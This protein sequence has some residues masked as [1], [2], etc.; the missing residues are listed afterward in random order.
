MA[1]VALLYAHTKNIKVF[2]GG[3]IDFNPEQ[4]IIEFNTKHRKGIGVSADMFLTPYVAVKGTLAKPRL[5]LNQKGALLASGAAVATGGI[6]MLVRAA[7]DRAAGTVDACQKYRDE[8]AG[9]T[10]MP[11]QKAK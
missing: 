1:N 3:M 10:P 6:S 5:G 7:A 9:H 8:F 2:C 4:L 11:A